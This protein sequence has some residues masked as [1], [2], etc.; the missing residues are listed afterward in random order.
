[1]SDPISGLFHKQHPNIRLT[2]VDINA[3]AVKT[4][5]ERFGLDHEVGNE[6]SLWKYSAHSFDVAFTVSVL[7]YIPRVTERLMHC[8]TAPDTT[9]HGEST[10]AGRRVETLRPFRTG[11]PCLHPSLYS[12][13]LEST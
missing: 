7:D 8:C 9:D 1:M 6:E 4:G 5:Q 11:N 2:G 12:W 3:Q 13:N 10:Y